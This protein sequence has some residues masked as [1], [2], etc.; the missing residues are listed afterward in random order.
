[1]LLR[2]DEK[3][4]TTT[5]PGDDTRILNEICDVASDQFIFFRFYISTFPTI[6]YGITAVQLIQKNFTLLGPRV[7]FFFHTLFFFYTDWPRSS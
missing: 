1:M 6:S 2:R 5:L 7:T 3:D 4:V